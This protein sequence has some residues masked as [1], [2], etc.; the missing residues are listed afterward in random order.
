MT[1][2]M[3]SKR[4]VSD[5]VSRSTYSYEV[6]VSMVR[7]LPFDVTVMALVHSIEATVIVLRFL[8]YSRVCPFA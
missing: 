5:V 3:V 7:E 4:I 6:S 1:F 2:D 8:G